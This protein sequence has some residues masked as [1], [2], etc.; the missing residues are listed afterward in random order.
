MKLVATDIDGTILPHRG[1]ISAR[2]AD[3]L[4]A[5]ADAGVHVVLV[6]ARPPRWM[7]PIADAL[8]HT[9]EAIVANGAA[10]M[11]LDTEAVHTQTTISADALLATAEVLRRELPGVKLAVESARGM[12]AE[13]GGLRHR[14]DFAPAEEGDFAEL[15]A[16]RGGEALKLLA[17]APGN[18]GAD[19]MVARVLPLLDGI[20]DPSHSAVDDSLLEF[21]PA[22]VSK[23]SALAAYADALGLTRDDVVAFGD[24]PNDIPMLEWAGTSYAV[25]GAHPDATAAAG[26]E[27]PSASDDGVAQ[28]IAELLGLEPQ[29]VGESGRPSGA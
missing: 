1:R 11:N 14:A 18:G 4:R 25:A 7:R 29:V 8:G 23:A 21:S 20:V 2:T 5:A 16:V 22:G 19:A 24:A 28:V 26:R 13:T 27:A 6:T 3:T 10:V 12:S 17:R 15:E 9:G